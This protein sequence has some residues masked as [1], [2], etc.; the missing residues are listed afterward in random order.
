MQRLKSFWA[1]NLNIRQFNWGGEKKVNIFI[2]F[3]GRNKVLPYI[4][5]RK[6]GEAQRC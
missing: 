4:C 3:V 2:F 5:N 1:N 6:N